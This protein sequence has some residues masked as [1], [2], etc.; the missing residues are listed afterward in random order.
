MAPLKIRL[1]ETIITSYS[2]FQMPFAEVGAELSH[3]IRFL[4]LCTMIVM[5]RNQ[6]SLLL[7][8]ASLATIPYHWYFLK[9]R[10]NDTRLKNL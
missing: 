1:G 2:V 3:R 10:H 6:A 9:T 4:V 5:D 7:Y 8:F